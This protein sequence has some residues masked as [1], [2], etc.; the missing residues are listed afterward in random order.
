MSTLQFYLEFH[1]IWI[2]LALCL[3]TYGTRRANSKATVYLS[4]I[5]LLNGLTLV[6]DLL[7][8]WSQGNASRVTDYVLYISAVL[9]PLMEHCQTLLTSYFIRTL[10][11]E[12]EETIDQRLFR[13]S[14]G[15]SIAGILLSTL[16][17]FFVV[18]FRIEEHVLSYTRY[19]YGLSLTFGIIAL[20]VNL[21][22]ILKRKMHFSLAAKIAM[23]TFLILLILAISTEYVYPEGTTIILIASTAILIAIYVSNLHASYTFHKKRTRQLLQ[24]QSDLLNAQIKPHF[25]FNALTSIQTL[26][27]IDPKEATEAATNFS[28]YMHQMLNAT[29]IDGLTNFQTEMEIVRNYLYIEKLRFGDQ[30][31]IVYDYPEDLDFM[32]PYLSIEPMVEN[33]V[34]HGLRGKLEG[35]TVTI[36]ARAN[37]EDALVRIQDDG[38]GFDCSQIDRCERVGFNNVKQ[39]IQL[40]CNG[41]LIVK[42]QIGA[43]TTIIM[44][45]PQKRR[46]QL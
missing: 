38:V 8:S 32:I 23:S 39:R 40:L 3:W 35:G 12:R 21:I 26:I 25:I 13:I 30:I 44:N 15:A 37:E 4:I 43:G 17:I 22:Q 2:S 20:G 7:L 18:I 6:A 27:D 24:T 1:G 9:L 10:L 31:Q 19:G 34:R 45:I 46:F 36:Y 11:E 41:E 16:S 29:Q 42:S 14:C 5:M 33:A 28:R